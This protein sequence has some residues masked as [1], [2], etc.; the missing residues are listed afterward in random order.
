MY[1][2][3]VLLFF[4]KRN[5]CQESSRHLSFSNNLFCYLFHVHTIFTS[6]KFVQFSAFFAVI[7]LQPP[8]ICLLLYPQ[9]LKHSILRTLIRNQL[10]CTH[11]ICRNTR[12]VNK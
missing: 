4:F 7:K 11:Q 6:T 1:D 3:S 2:F 8:K 5:K 10:K 9:R 12:K